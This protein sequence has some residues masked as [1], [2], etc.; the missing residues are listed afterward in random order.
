[1]HFIEIC[2]KHTAGRNECY[3]TVL[4]NNK[5]TEKQQVMKNVWTP[6]YRYI[7]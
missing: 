7:P 2:V 6:S 3:F 5:R 4:Q 1:M